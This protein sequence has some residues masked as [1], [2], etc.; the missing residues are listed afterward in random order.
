M[1]SGSVPLSHNNNSVS[2]NLLGTN[3]QFIN[4]IP[5]SNLKNNPAGSNNQNMGGPSNSNNNQF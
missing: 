4:A 5:Q 3:N 2:I 1:N